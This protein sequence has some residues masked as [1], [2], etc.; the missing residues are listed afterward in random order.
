MVETLVNNVEAT[1]AQSEKY[2]YIHTH[3]IFNV[4]SIRLVIPPAANWNDLILIHK[5][6]N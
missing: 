2:I 6:F 5:S 1:H 3:K 4:D